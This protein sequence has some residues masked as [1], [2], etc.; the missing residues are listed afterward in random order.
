[1]FFVPQTLTLN[2]ID[3]L[4]QNEYKIMTKEIMVLHNTTV[5]RKPV[6]GYINIVYI[7][8]VLTYCDSILMRNS[9]TRCN[10]TAVSFPDNNQDTR[11]DHLA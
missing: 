11:N 4:L 2:C 10:T 5:I 6:H 8:L 9:K 3:T 1:M 7:C